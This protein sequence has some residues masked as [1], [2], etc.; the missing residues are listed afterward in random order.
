[1]LSIISLA[2]L[3]VIGLLVYIRRKDMVQPEPRK[4][5]IKGIIYGIISVFVALPFALM[6][7]D[8]GGSIL[9][10]AFQAFFQAA[11][12]EECAKFL[13]LWL[14]VRKMKEFDEPFDGIVYAACIGLGFAGF[15]NICYLI[16]AAADGALVSTAIVRDT[17]SVPGHFCFQVT[18]GYFF[19]I[20]HFGSKAT[21]RRNYYMALAVP[22]ALHGIFDMLL[23]IE[24]EYIKVILLIAWLAFCIWMFRA[25]AKRINSM[26]TPAIPV[27]QPATPPAFTTENHINN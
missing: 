7:P 23:M 12:P 27:E 17:F 9:G 5:I 19:A 6:M 11:I 16:N 4:N 1:M 10:G 18:M 2:L 26:R 15:E 21:A 24:N 22:I 3:P 14:L 20:A 25:S 13:M 8:T